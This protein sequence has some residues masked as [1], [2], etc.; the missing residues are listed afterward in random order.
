VPDD[1]PSPLEQ[2]IGRRFERHQQR[3]E[4]A[5]ATRSGGHR[6]AS[7]CNTATGVAAAIGKTNA[8][9]A[10]MAVARHR[11]PGRGDAAPPL[12]VGLKTG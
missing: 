7:S 11:P 1:A 6:R 3:A 4:V 8:N 2:A 10:R 9:A 5:H 12:A